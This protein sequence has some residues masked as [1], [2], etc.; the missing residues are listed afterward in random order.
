MKKKGETLGR[1]EQPTMNRF[2]REE[3]RKKD[4]EGQ[5]VQWGPW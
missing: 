1:K 3:K 2:L 5:G 4:E